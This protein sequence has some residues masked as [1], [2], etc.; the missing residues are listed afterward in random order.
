MKKFFPWSVLLASL[1]AQSVTAQIAHTVTTQNYF[2]CIAGQSGGGIPAGSSLIPSNSMSAY[3]SG[4]FQTLQANGFYQTTMTASSLGFSLTESCLNLG[5]GS[6]STGPNHTLWVLGSSQPVTGTL[7]VTGSATTFSPFNLRTVNV[8]VDNDGSVEWSLAAGGALS[9]PLTVNGSRSI[10]ITSATNA[11]IGD[12][13][14]NANMTFSVSATKETYGT[15][16]GA[17]LTLDSN[18]PALGTNW[19]LTTTGVDAISPFAVTFFGDR[20]SAVPFVTL[21]FNAPGCDAHLQSVF[22]SLSGANSSGIASV[23]VAVPSS[24][25]LIG[26]ELSGQSVCLTGNNAALLHSSNGLEGTI[27]G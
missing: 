17:P 12:V 2:L 26:A 11:A 8:D 13:Q 25:A 9:I 5:S 1:M 22:G 27:G 15:G 16:C 20:G 21:G 4:G 23:T 24:A 10:R 6:A 18:V 7:T 14:I 19:V 3:Y